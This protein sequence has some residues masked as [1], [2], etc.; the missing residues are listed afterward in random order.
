[1]SSSIRVLFCQA[2]GINKRIERNKSIPPAKNSSSMLS[3]EEESEPFS[4]IKGAA[5]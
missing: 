5:S 4:L 2:G 1:M 3:N